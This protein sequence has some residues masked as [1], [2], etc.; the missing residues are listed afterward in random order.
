MVPRS[1]SGQ[2]GTTLYIL[3]AVGDQLHGAIVGIV[4]KLLQSAIRHQKQDHLYDRDKAGSPYGNLPRPRAWFYG[5][6]YDDYRS[7]GCDEL[8]VRGSW[9]GSHP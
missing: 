6:R 9:I 7:L 3:C 5:C 2:P 4:P 1:E 8:F